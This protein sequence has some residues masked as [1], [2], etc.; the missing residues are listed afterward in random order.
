MHIYGRVTCNKLYRHYENFWGCNRDLLKPLGIFI[1]DLHK[2]ILFNRT[3]SDPPGNVQ[4]P[5]YSSS[6]FDGAS[7]ELIF[8][9]MNDPLYVN[10]DFKLIAWY[11]EDLIN[12]D[13]RENDGQT[14]VDVYAHFV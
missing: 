8:N 6:L 13:E 9:R 1:T 10:Q 4:L 11:G 5:W 2:R 3:G 7:S 14:C 12:K